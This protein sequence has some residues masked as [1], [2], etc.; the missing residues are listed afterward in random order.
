MSVRVMSMVFERYPN[1]GGEMLLALA[2]A[3]HSHD[4]GTHI[5]PSIAQLAAKTRQSERSVQ[6][7]LR[8]MEESGWLILMN[9]GNGG[10][11][12]RREYSINPAWLKGAEIAPI[13]TPVKGAIHDIKGATGDLKGAIDDKKGCNG[14]HPHI[15]IIE[16]SITIKESSADPKAQAVPAIA[17]ESDPVFFRFPLNDRT[18]YELTQS[19]VEQFASLYPAVDI[20]SHLR[21]CLG[22]NI[23]NPSRRKTRSGILNHINTWLADKQNKAPAQAARSATPAHRNDRSGAVA[24]IFGS[25]E[26]QEKEFIDVN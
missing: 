16:P 14:L 5:Y 20:V 22:W 18:E 23:A 7:Q 8:K 13:V 26:P 19:Q 2:L 17:E 9:S 6:Y 4:D 24:A 12:Q 1:G 11:N 10:R 3:D 21:A 15:T 25:D